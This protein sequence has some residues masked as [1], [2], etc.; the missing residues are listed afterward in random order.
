MRSPACYSRCHSQRSPL[1]AQESDSDGV[2][3]HILE[4]LKAGRAPHVEPF[5]GR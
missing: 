2:E 3:R 1:R 4:A 5:S